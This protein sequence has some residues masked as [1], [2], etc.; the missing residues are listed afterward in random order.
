M[1]QAA[2]DDNDEVKTQ[3]NGEIVISYDYTPKDTNETVTKTVK[4]VVTIVN[5]VPQLQMQQPGKAMKLITRGSLLSNSYPKSVLIDILKY[6]WPSNSTNYDGLTVAS[7][8]CLICN[9]CNIPNQKDLSAIA[10]F[11]NECRNENIKQELMDFEYE[12][13]AQVFVTLH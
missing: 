13:N 8:L 1:A 9:N 2:N 5:G 7:A 6:F 11:F 12:L 10:K 4:V 3:K